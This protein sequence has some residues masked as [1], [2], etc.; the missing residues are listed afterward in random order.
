MT[1]L[2]NHGGP[3]YDVEFH[4]HEFLLASGGLAEILQLLL[5]LHNTGI[6]PLGITT[7]SILGLNITHK[8]NNTQLK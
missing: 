7:L 6:I 1:E 5:G 3:V 2:N 8:H 4:P